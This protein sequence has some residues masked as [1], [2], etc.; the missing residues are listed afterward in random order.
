MKELAKEFKKQNGTAVPAEIILI[1]GAAVLMGYGFR[2]MTTDV[3]AVIHASSAM[4]E[5]VGKVG[6]RY[7]LPHGWLNSDFMCT[8]SYSPKLEQFSVYYKT[9]SN[10]L[11][12]RTVSAEYLIAMK[13]RSGRK[14][15]NDLSDI[16]G[17]L[18]EHERRG[19]PISKDRIEIAVRNLYGNWNGFSADAVS[20]IHDALEKG[21]YET[22][23][24]AVMEEEKK[25]K[26]ML[27]QF[28]KKYPGV[29]A[30][31][32]VNEILA[33]LKADNAPGRQLQKGKKEIER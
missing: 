21:N 2:E 28:G 8:D 7:N 32:N 4:K 15:K 14:Y 6:D 19:D 29:A 17:I 11:Q 18:A 31:S 12:I 10:V 24:A 22:I 13:L 5:A 1:G 16:I 33:S 30:Q 27:I 25:S 23:Y 3:D 20:F 9:F 26:D